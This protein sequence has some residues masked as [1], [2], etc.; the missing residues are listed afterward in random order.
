MENLRELLGNRY[1]E[2]DK[3]N[4]IEKTAYV[5]GSEL[6]EYNFDDLLCLVTIKTRIYK[7]SSFLG[8]GG[9]FRLWGGQFHGP[10]LYET[11]LP[12]THQSRVEHFLTHL[13]CIV[14]TKLL[15]GSII[16]F[17]RENGVHNVLRDF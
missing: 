9:G 11:L 10:P 17:D 15:N 3:L 6:W 12:S 8:G 13:D 16:I 2:F 4:S 7:F 1:A 14:N 5:L